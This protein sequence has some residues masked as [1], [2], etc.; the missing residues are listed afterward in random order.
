MGT[1]ATSI[2]TGRSGNR[3]PRC[4]V[5]TRLYGK[6]RKPVS[7]AACLVREFA[8]SGRRKPLFYRSPSR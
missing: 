3:R 6:R 2:E 5:P 7:N 4:A 8:M 1:S